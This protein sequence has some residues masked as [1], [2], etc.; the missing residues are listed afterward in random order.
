MTNCDSP[1]R[2]DADGGTGSTDI[3]ETSFH[4]GNTREAVVGA[5]TLKSANSVDVHQSTGL[6][7]YCGVTDLECVYH[8]NKLVDET[9]VSNTLSYRSTSSSPSGAATAG[10]RCTPPPFVNGCGS[11]KVGRQFDDDELAQSISRPKRNETLADWWTLLCAF[12]F[13]VVTGFNF[14]AY[15]ILYVPLT[16]LFGSSRASVGWIQSIEFSLGSLLG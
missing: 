12:L 16:E 1:V 6:T 10:S 5:A 2:C 15:A 11:A 9:D 14:S 13:N 4:A 3:N 8:T 7:A